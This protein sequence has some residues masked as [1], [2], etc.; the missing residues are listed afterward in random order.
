MKMEPILPF[1]ERTCPRL[2]VVV[3]CYNEEAVLLMLEARLAAACRDQVGEDYEIV[4][5]NDGSTDRTWPLICVLAE[6][7]PRVLGVDLSRNHGHQLAVTAGLQVCRGDLV[8][9]IDADLQDPPELLGAMIARIE[10]GADVV[11]GQRIA[12]HGESTFK[13]GTASVFYKLLNRLAEQ[14]IPVDT[15]DFRLMTRRVVDQLNAMPERYRFIRGMVSW[16]GFEQVA[17]PYERAPR[18]AG[19][20]HYPLRRMIRL[21]FDAI[22]SFSTVPLRIASHLGMLT[23]VAGFA[24]LSWAIWRWFEEGTIVGWTSII[25]VMLIMGSIQLIILGVFG[26]YLGRLY[27]ESK[28]RPLFIVRE[29]RSQSRASERGVI[30]VPLTV[31][32]FDPRG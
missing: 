7:N 26:D 4:L 8:M 28:G 25:A 13:R 10:A 29:V 1:A 22:T 30:Q 12:R 19:E 23:G 21:A 5:V 31:A 14:D 9:M 27:I 20:T 17:L 11:Y 6:R 24:M 15:G 3:P 18:A 32:A 16:I 2:S